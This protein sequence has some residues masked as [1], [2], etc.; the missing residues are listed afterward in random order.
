MKLEEK[1]NKENKGVVKIKTKSELNAE[2]SELI[3][4]CNNKEITADVVFN[5]IAY[6][7]LHYPS[8]KVLKEKKLKLKKLNKFI[9]YT[10]YI[11]K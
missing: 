10:V 2:L 8:K 3:R 6:I 4:R 1:K 7:N 5:L 9:L 11:T